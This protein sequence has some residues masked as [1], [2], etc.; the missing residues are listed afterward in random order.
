VAASTP[1]PR[2][3]IVRNPEPDQLRLLGKVARMYHERGMRQPQIAAELGLSQPRVSRLLRQASEIGIVRTVVTMPPGTYTELEEEIQSRYGLRDVVVVDADGSEGQVI[4]ALGAAAAAYLDVTLIGRHIV[5]VSSWSETLLAAV[6][7]LRPK[8]LPVADQ[9]IQLLGGLGDPGVQMQATR[10]TG[11]LADLLGAVP[12]FLAA[13]GLVATATARKAIL[14]D[15]SVGRVAA[16]FR[17]ITDAL[18]GIGS[19][20][21]SPLLRRSGNI[22]GETEQE[23]LRSLGAVGD[24]C[25]RYFDAD[26]KP[27]HS[28]LEQRLIGINYDELMAIPRRI[29]VAGGERKFSAIRGAL[30]GRWVSVLITDL[31]MARRLIADAG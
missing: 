1:A 22:M 9:V 25:F 2:G 16:L 27:I 29:G 7:L 13:P 20:D 5:G 28:R 26:G 6:D 19:L 10:L 8:A 17:T 30:R 24:V 15:P 23:E 3:R 31:A 18:V 14:N 4:P 21:P 11:R 12:V